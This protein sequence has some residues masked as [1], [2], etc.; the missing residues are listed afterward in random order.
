LKL[1]VYIC[2]ICNLYHYSEEDGDKNTGLKPNTNI[3]MIPDTWHCPI[4]GVS[5][6]ALSPLPDD[7]EQ[8]KR[9][10]NPNIA[11]NLVDVRK[12]AFNKLKGICTVN[13]VCDG[14][15]SRFCMGQKY[16][17]PIGLGAAGKGLGFTANVAALD[18]IKIKQR[19][20]SKHAEPELTAIF[21]GKTITFPILASSLSGVS[22]SMGGKISEKEFALS[23]LQG[24]KDAG[25]IGLIGNT[26]DN[27][28]ELTGV[29]AVS[30]VGWGIP[31]FK[32]QTNERLLELIKLAEDAG[33]IAVGVDLDGVGSTNWERMGKPVFRKSLNELRELVDSTSLPFIAKSIMSVD[34][35]IA[36][37][38]SGVSCIDVS[39]HGGRILDSTRGVADVL[40]E[41]VHAVKIVEKSDTTI[42]AGGGI[43]TGYDVFKLLALGADAVLIGRDIVRAALGG[44]PV[45]IKLHFNYLQSDLRRSM[46][47]TSCNKI[48]DIT[49][50]NL[51]I[52]L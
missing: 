44:G 41:I 48:T 13:K 35:A 6:F 29:E 17:N 42:T 16:G 19:L 5:K 25:T 40:S 33:A 2:N 52:N 27:N 37:V 22:A 20:I 11:L 39:N 38:D 9:E 4:C 18:N 51:D 24:A 43:R 26:S 21:L 36:A 15:P 47:L 28:Q 32:P 23:V 50:K 3:S 14:Q 31:I 46:L 7:K 8:N 10:D 45:G 1:A 12:N 30:K 49:E 34:D